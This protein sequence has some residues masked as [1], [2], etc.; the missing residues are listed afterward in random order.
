[1]KARAPA[2]PGKPATPNVYSG[3]T[4]PRGVSPVGQQNPPHMQD[5]PRDS[6]V[7]LTVVLPSGLEKRSVVN[8]R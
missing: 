4:P 3:Q 2:P 8:G 7:D 6:V 1:M 5:D